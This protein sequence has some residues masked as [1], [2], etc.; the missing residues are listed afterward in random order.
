MHNIYI[1]CIIFVRLP[2]WAEP[3]GPCSM[4]ASKTNKCYTLYQTHSS[5]ENFLRSLWGKLG[6]FPLS[7]RDELHEVDGASCDMKPGEGDGCRMWY[8]SP[9]PW[10]GPRQCSIKWYQGRISCDILL[11]IHITQIMHKLCILC[12]YYANIMQKLR[13]NYA[14]IMQKLWRNYIHFM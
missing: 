3:T 12:K 2:G 7:M 10:H 8:V 4:G 11:L 5:W 9:G 1:I 6:P 13:R 14:E